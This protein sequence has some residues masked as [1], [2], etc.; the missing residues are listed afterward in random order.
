MNTRQKLTAFNTIIIK[1]VLRFT[2]IWIQT[3]IPPMV[4]MAL[5]FAIFGRLIGDRIGEMSGFS[6]IQYIAPGLIMMSIIN[7]S[8]SNV[9]SSFFSTK[10]HGNIQELLVS[11]LPNYIIILGYVGGGI[12]RGLAVGIGVTIVAMCFTEII[13]YNIWIIFV[14]FFLTSFLFSLGGFINAVY[15]NSFDGMT[16]I[17]TFILTPLT[18]LGGVFYSIELLSPFWQGFSHINP[19]FYMVNGF[20][21][22]FLG[23]SDINIW[24]CFGILISF[25]IGLFIFSL[26]LLNTGKGTRE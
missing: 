12:A 6:Y 20:R 22:G 10:F 3:L 21:Y 1:E 4:T 19:I 11:P 25:I 14:I 13:F 24:V 8:Y 7:N 5:Y 23:V 9:V 2:R 26:H 18:Y 15:A 16:I 17:P